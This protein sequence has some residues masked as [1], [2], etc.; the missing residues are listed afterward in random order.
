M[1][2]LTNAL[3]KYGCHEPRNED[4]VDRVVLGHEVPILYPP[5]SDKYRDVF[6]NG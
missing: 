2:L 3:N 4:V 1:E 6:V 5:L